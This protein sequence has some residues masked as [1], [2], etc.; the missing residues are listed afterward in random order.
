M[1]TLEIEVEVYLKRKN[2][3]IDPDLNE[4]RSRKSL[5]LTGTLAIIKRVNGYGEE[6]LLGY[7]VNKSLNA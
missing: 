7:N 4:D 1:L 6:F 2:A 5:T 3:K